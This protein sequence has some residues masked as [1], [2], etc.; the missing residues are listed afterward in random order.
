MRQRC[1]QTMA[2]IAPL[3][4][5]AVLART[6][7]SVGARGLSALLNL[8]VAD[9]TRRPATIRALLRIERREMARFECSALRGAC[10]TIGARRLAIACQ[11]VEDRLSSGPTATAP[12]GRELDA[13]AEDTIAAIADWRENEGG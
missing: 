4:D 12:V 6:G 10:Q 8:F 1:E 5:H 3:L 13:I 9:L 11:A 2:T 7:R